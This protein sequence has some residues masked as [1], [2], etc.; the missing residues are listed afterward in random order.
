M[1]G[2]LAVGEYF[3][4]ASVYCRYLAKQGLAYYYLGQHEYEQ[5]I[6]PLEE[7]AAQ[8][9]FQAF[10]IAGLVVVYANLGDDEKANDANGRLSIEMR[11]SLSKQS[12]QMF[13]LLNKTLDELFERAQAERR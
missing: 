5:A 9:D 1:R 7:L 3:P 13:E 4:D 8:S 12:P 10:G 6:K 11:K 2:E